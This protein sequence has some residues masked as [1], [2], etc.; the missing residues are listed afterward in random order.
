MIIIHNIMNIRGNKNIY[1]PIVVN[2]MHNMM[3]KFDQI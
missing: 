3:Y 2:Y 1:K